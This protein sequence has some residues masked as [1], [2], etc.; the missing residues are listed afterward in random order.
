MKEPLFLFDGHCDTPVELWLREQPLRE[1]HLAVSLEQAKPLGAWAQFFAICTPWIQN[2]LPHTEQYRQALE[3][4]L[5]QL[6]ENRD[7]IT[8]CRTAAEAK[9]AM[10]SGKRAAFLAI[11]GAE[12][13]RCDPG[14]LDEAYEQGVRMISLVWNLENALGGSCQT[15][16]GLTAQGKAFFRRAQKLGMLVDVSHLSERGFWDM[17]ELAERPIVASHSN[18]AAVCPHPR[19]LTDEQFRTICQLG[20]TAGINLYP[21]FLTQENGAA[22]EDVY[23]HI[24]HFLQLGGEGHIAIGTDFDGCETLPEGIGGIRDMPWLAD[25]LLQRG[26]DEQTVTKIFGQSLWKVVENI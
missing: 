14:R 7:A 5:T 8:L 26:M 11:E 24:D 10:Q 13:L 23:R 17:A 1:N 3:Y 22:V 20:G 12:A 19:N 2:K 15:G 16:T 21:P 6:D 9:H 18:S 4:F 25:A